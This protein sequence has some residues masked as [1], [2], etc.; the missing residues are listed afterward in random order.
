MPVF[1]RSEYLRLGATNELISNCS[2]LI[3]YLFIL[4][5]E[6][7]DLTVGAIGD[8]PKLIFISKHIICISKKLFPVGEN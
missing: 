5:S 7:Q 3:V 2:G 8:T 1:F 6:W 4:F